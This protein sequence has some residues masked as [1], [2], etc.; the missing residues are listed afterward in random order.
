MEVKPCMH[1]FMHVCRQERKRE[2]KKKE[3]EKESFDVVFVGH[4][5]CM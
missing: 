3:K 2:R 1:A 5:V 4:D